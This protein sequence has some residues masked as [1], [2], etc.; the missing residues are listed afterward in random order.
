[1]RNVQLVNGTSALATPARRDDERKGMRLCQA[2]GSIPIARSTNPFFIGV[3]AIIMMVSI[4]SFVLSDVS[5]LLTS[6]AITSNGTEV[7]HVVYGDTL[8]SIAQ[9]Y[10][11]P[12]CSTTDVVTWLIER[13]DLSSSRIRPGQSLEVPRSPSGGF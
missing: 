6:Q 8:W 7:V 11:V 1:M 5:K 4:I 3:C 12:G 2:R 13:N 9:R 10:A